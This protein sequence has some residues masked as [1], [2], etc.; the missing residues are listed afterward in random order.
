MSLRIVIVDDNADAADV[1]ALSLQALGH[2]TEVVHKAEAVWMVQDI[3]G[4][5]AFLLDIGLPGI[6]GM[7]LARSL[8]DMPETQ[9]SRFI[10]ITGGS[11]SK[12]AALQAGFDEYL[13]KPIQLERLV[14]LLRN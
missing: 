8:R 2:R 7:T 1:L 3:G 6:D 9:G 14:G 10:A 11:A 13:C 12:S 5:D 4:V